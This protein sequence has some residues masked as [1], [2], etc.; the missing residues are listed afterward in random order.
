LPVIHAQPRARLTRERIVRAAL[1]LVDEHGL[2]GLSMRKLGAELGVEAM[3]LY[4]HVPSKAA[5]LDGITDAL[6]SQVEIHPVGEREWADEIRSAAR[7]LRRVAL[8]HPYLV[9][10]VATRP[11]RTATAMRLVESALA[12]LR[13]AG[14]DPEDAV[15]AY[16]LLMGYVLGAISQELTGPLRPRQQAAD[17]AD[18]RR[19]HFPNL[20]DRVEQGID[21]PERAF[22]FGLDVILSGL[23]AMLGG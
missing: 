5:L 21:D 10:L 20:L 17:Y 2:E 16:L 19:E 3:S 11:P 4:N 22:D 13:H 9:T 8:S 14:F 12:I 1:E 15:R 6:L 18:L 23:A 7:S